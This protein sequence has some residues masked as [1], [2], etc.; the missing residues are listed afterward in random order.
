MDEFRS[1]VRKELA[2][3]S[4]THRT[5]AAFQQGLYAADSTRRTYAEMRRRA[6]AWLT[7]GISVVLDGSFYLPALKR[8]AEAEYLAA[9]IPG[10]VRFDIDAIA[11]HS[12]PLPHMLPGTDEFAAAVGKLGIGDGMTIIVYDG[13]GLGGAARVWWTFRVFGRRMSSCSTEGR[14]A[15]EWLR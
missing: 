14:L 4:P 8:D 5:G 9:H 10:A 15:F 11:N 1:W 2:G 12:S 3:L 6:R 13:A 7:R